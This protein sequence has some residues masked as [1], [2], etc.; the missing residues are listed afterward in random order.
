[1]SGQEAGMVGDREHPH[2]RRGRGDRIGR[3]NQERE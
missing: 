2:R 3:G 1:M